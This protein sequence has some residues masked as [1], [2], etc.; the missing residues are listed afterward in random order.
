MLKKKNYL[1]LNLDVVSRLFEL[2]VPLGLG[3]LGVIHQPKNLLINLR[4][5]RFNGVIDNCCKGNI[6][7]VLVC[8]HPESII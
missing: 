5:F 3:D 6:N 8:V 7:K 1:G 4:F 2:E